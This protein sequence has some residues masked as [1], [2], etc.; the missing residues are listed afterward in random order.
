MRPDDIV[1]ALANKPFQPFRLC[2]TDGTIHEVRHP[3]LVVVGRSTVFLGRPGPGEYKQVFEDYVWIALLHI[4]RME[5]IP[6]QA[7]TASN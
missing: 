4:N 3:E 5:P 2:L 6:K 7:S 1:K